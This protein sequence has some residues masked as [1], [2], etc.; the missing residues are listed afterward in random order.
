MKRL[1]LQDQSLLI[2]LD[3]V[4]EI[5]ADQEWIVTQCGLLPER[6]HTTDKFVVQAGMHSLHRADTLEECQE[7]LVN[8]IRAI[9]RSPDT[10]VIVAKPG[11]TFKFRT[12]GNG[13]Y[14][15][16][17]N[18]SPENNHVSETA[19]KGASSNGS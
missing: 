10:C 15:T 1:Y 8:L 3:K 18:D 6:P 16:I 11:G 9:C 14:I 12:P 13:S 5:Q 19:K 4:D 17:P 2:N 7:Y